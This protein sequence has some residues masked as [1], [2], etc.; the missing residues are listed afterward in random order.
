VV[1]FDS[2][3]DSLH[4]GRPVSQLVIVIANSQVTYG[5]QKVSSKPSN[6]GFVPEGTLKCV[7][8]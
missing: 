1:P 8:L 3:A 7:R 5:A 2:L 6:S 4:T